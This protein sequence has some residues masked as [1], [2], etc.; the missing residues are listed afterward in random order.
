MASDVPLAKVLDAYK[1]AIEYLVQ[2][3]NCGVSI[4]VLHDGQK[5]YRRAGVRDS[6]TGEDIDENTVV[7]ISSLTKPFV[8]VILFT[9]QHQRKIDLYDSVQRLLNLPHPLARNGQDLRVVD[10]LDHRTNFY[11]C[12]RLWEGRQGKIN[13][14]DCDT[15]LELLRHLPPNPQYADDS[16]FRNTRNYSNIAYAILGH[17]IQRVSGSHWSELAHEM[18]DELGMTRSTADKRARCPRDGNVASAHCAGVDRA[19]HDLPEATTDEDV[20]R[21]F[22]GRSATAAERIKPSQV[23]DGLTAVAAAA[24]IYSTTADMLKFSS[25]YLELWNGRRDPDSDLDHGIV[26]SQQYLRKKAEDHTYSYA[27]GWNVVNV[28]W[29][30]RQRAPGADGENHG[31]L[32]AAGRLCPQSGNHLP[33]SAKESQEIRHLTTYHGGNMVGVTSFAELFLDSNTGV[34]VLCCARSF[35]IDAAN[36]IGSRIAE[37][38]VDKLSYSQVEGCVETD[39]RLADR[40]AAM[41]AVEIYRYES[42]LRAEY[43][44][45]LA[46]P[47]RFPGYV[48]KY[49]LAPGIYLEIVASRD[50]THLEFRPQGDNPGYPLRAKRSNPRVLSAVPSMEANHREGLG[51]KNA[52][53]LGQYELTF[54]GLDHGQCGW[55]SWRFE[56]G[57]DLK[58]CR[59]LREAGQVKR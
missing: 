11:R 9:L 34:V 30:A 55:V 6:V 53:N 5:Q 38:L 23:S 21:Q 56:S 25:R 41:Y 20:F 59:Y 37:I 19:L 43:D 3:G 2:R 7:L 27:S 44:Q 18:F 17:I 33:F 54:S 1:P 58:S 12:D 14:S 22:I 42:M 31:R 50:G 39:R 26:A 52:L 46:L 47:S 36:M 32:E 13:I 35:Q 24:G 29:D 4:G 51:G 48:G 16:D 8:A 10:L 28:P 49:V 45:V 40:S 57:L 15:F